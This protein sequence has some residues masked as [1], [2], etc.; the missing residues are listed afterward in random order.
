MTYEQNEL[1]V[2]GGNPYFLYSF[3][4]GSVVNYFTSGAADVV[5]GGNTYLA[6]PISHQGINQSG[7][8]ERVSLDIVFP[9]SDTFAKSYFTP[10]YSD[11]QTVTIL[12]GHYDVAGEYEVM[13][14]GRVVSY[15]ADGDQITLACESIQ[16][17]MRR[18]GL[19]AKYQRTCRH[20]LYGTGCGVDINNFWINATVA[21]ITGL[22]VTLTFDGADEEADDYY[23]GGIIE[24]AGQYSFI[25]SDKSNVMNIQY[26]IEGLAVS[27]VVRVAAGC[28]LSKTQCHAKFNNILNFGGSPGIP[29]ENPFGGNGGTRLE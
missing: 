23:R 24:K 12:R 28:N 18:L 7:K 13:W 6:S 1:S 27:D 25:K 14:K 17:T 2:S 15:E 19:R 20:A 8:L 26:P 11:V 9:K 22:S 10:N 3:A 5:Y 16:T 21:S 29:T 4:V